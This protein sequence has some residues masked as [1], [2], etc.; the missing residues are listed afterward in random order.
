MS[1]TTATKSDSEESSDFSIMSWVRDK[2]TGVPA[3]ASTEATGTLLTSPAKPK[4][5]SYV[6]E[7][8]SGGGKS[9]AD[10]IFREAYAAQTSGKTAQAVE[11][12]RT[13]L[14]VYKGTRVPL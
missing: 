8:S 14:D 3:K 1:S 10:E 6:V 12:Y 5:I 7:S 4:K 13:V 2:I 9:V 11:K